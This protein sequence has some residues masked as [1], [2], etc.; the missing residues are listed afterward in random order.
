MQWN[1][2]IYKAPLDLLNIFRS[3]VSDQ[4]CQKW[5]RKLQPV[6]KFYFF[7]VTINKFSTVLWFMLISPNIEQ[8]VFQYLKN[9][10][11]HE[12]SV[13]WIQTPNNPNVMKQFAIKT[14]SNMKVMKNVSFCSHMRRY[15]TSETSFYTSPRAEISLHPYRIILPK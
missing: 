1:Y 11:V 13:W 2:K 10:N 4:G 5:L 12:F 9:V 6:G 15:W 3:K 14:L 7:I 8:A